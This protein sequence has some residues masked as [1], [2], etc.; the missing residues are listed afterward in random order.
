[1]KLAVVYNPQEPKL[2]PGA[3]S[4]TYRDMFDAVLARFESIQHVTQ[5]ASAAD[6]EAD[7]VLIYDLHS[8]YDIT[9]DGL[10]AHRAT[11][12][13]YL[14]DPHQLDEA[15][16]YRGGPTVQKLGAAKRCRRATQRGVQF[17]ICPYRDGFERY[18]RPHLAAE[19]ELFWFPPAPRPRRDVQSL[20]ADREP[21]VLVNGHLWPGREG[22]RPYEFRRWAVQQPQSTTIK[23]A[24]DGG[25][26][27]GALYQAFLSR[28]AG[29]LA[30]CDTYVV[31]KYLE[32]PLAGCVCFAQRH[33][34]YTEMGF[35]HEHSAIFVDRDN[36]AAAIEAFVRCPQQYQ[37]IAD[38]GREIAG[39]WT[40]TRFAE[41][42][43]EHALAQRTT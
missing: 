33:D 8:S 13:T 40:A 19:I 23:H 43:Y 16:T 4:Q 9:L 10:S 35:G 22:F 12:Y 14:N 17:V 29:A 5:S 31:P 38:K 28:Y 15:V 36:Y 7:V 2:T 25:A 6:I 21:A 20:L 26:A 32:I 24:L 30:A 3:Y 18:L 37:A 11:V 1:M 39:Q 27:A 41:V 42:L 34:E